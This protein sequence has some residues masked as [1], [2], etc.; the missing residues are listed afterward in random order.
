[1]WRL[2][3]LKLTRKASVRG[4]RVN[5]R[6]GAARAERGGAAESLE[7]RLLLSASVLTYHND[8][9][10][11]GQNT[12]ETVLTPSNVN[13]TSF[14]KLFTANVDGQVYGQPLYLPGLTI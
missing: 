10:S 11:D 6:R 7:T 9:A 8:N 3:M 14:G 4:L 13:S 5:R 2:P 1:M 12:Q